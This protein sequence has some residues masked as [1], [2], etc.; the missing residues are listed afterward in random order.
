[1]A[2]VGETKNAH[3]TFVGKPLPKGKRTQCHDAEDPARLETLP[4]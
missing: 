2:G 4:P 1:M 3:R